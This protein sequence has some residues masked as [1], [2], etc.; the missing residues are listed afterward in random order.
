[1]TEKGVSLPLLR[2]RRQEAGLSQEELADL[3]GVGVSTIM[4]IENGAHAR[5]A[6]LGKLA[7]ALQL[8]RTALLREEP[9][10]E[11]PAAVAGNYAAVQ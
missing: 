7:N 6:T 2:Q 11:R 1:M 10:K 3:A 8:K 4:R 9:Q 5:Y